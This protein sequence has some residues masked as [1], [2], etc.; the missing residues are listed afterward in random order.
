MLSENWMKQWGLSINYISFHFIHQI[1]QGK[2]KTNM[3]LITK[4]KQLF[5]RYL[6]HQGKKFDQMKEES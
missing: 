3:L 1:Y 2:R 4:N 6:E 5:R